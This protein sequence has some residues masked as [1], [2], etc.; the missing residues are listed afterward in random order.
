MKTAALSPPPRPPRDGKFGGSLGEPDGGR[1][2][3]RHAGIL[4]WFRRSLKFVVVV[5]FA[6][7][8]LQLVFILFQTV[9]LWFF[10]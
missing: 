3:G 2:F 5:L 1:K 9:R 10:S 7:A 6:V 4:R 8:V